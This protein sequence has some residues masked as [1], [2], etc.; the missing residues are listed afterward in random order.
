LAEGDQAGTQSLLAEAL[1]ICRRR[2]DKRVAAECLIA[3][4]ALAASFADPARAAR[5]CGAAEGLRETT[6]ATP[7]PLERLLEQRH[8]SSILEGESL[9]A[10]WEKGHALDLDQAVAYA[11]ERLSVVEAVEPPRSDR[12]VTS[13]VSKPQ[14]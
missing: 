2:G 10:D 12:T 3:T 7:S 14:P 8:L 9:R 4:A 5:L 13:P 1:A 11:L 6:G